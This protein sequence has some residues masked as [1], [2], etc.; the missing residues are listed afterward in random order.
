MPDKTQVELAIEAQSILLT[1]ASDRRNAAQAEMSKLETSILSLRALLA[2]ESDL[3]SEKTK[4]R[5][6]QI[7]G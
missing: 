3:G 6:D 2:F 1:D 4:A 5:I 7:R